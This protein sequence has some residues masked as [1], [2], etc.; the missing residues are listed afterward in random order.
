MLSGVLTSSGVTFMIEYPRKPT[1][2]VCDWPTLADSG[3]G[4]GNLP[5]RFH[6]QTRYYG[7]VGDCWQ[8]YAREKALLAPIPTTGAFGR[9]A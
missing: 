3:R 4:R 5:C 9:L 7:L 1:E 8:G 6:P 2:M